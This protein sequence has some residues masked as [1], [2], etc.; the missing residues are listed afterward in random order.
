MNEPTKK[1]I[2]TREYKDVGMYT[3]PYCKVVCTPLDF[4]ED[5][6]WCN[7][8]YKCPVCFE[9]VLPHRTMKK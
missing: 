3:C 9:D 6:P 2:L 7:T 5:G 4:K 8:G 1:L